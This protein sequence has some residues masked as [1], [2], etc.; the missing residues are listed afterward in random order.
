[1]A[2]SLKC[3]NS[4]LSIL[5]SSDLLSLENLQSGR[6]KKLQMLIRSSSISRKLI[7]RAVGGDFNNSIR[8]LNRA[9]SVL[10]SVK[11]SLLNT[12]AQGLSEALGALSPAIEGSFFSTSPI[13]TLRVNEGADS[14]PEG[15]PC[16]APDAIGKIE[17]PADGASAGGFKGG[18]VT[19]FSADIV[20]SGLSRSF[21][22]GIVF[23]T[24]D[25]KD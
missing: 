20:T 2:A 15:A 6:S 22:L 18:V 14:N 8:V 12:V 7:R 13:E 5:N 4:I 3:A 9:S 17:S 24:T 1:M 23:T 19:F 10:I 25:R 11:S 21:Y 16:K